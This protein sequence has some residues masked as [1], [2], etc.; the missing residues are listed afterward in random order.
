M[1]QLRALSVAI[2]LGLNMQAMSAT[3]AIQPL[4]SIAVEVNGSIITYGDIERL[5]KELKSRAGNQGVA[6][7]QFVQ[8]AK[9]RLIERALLADAARQQNLKVN[10]AGIDQELEQRAKNDN[11][12]VEKL[13]AKARSL[14][15]TREAYR[16]EVAKDML[17]AYMLNDANAS[18]NISD[19]QINEAMKA[20]NL[21]EAE[22]YTVYTIRRIVLNADN[23]A[24]MP[25]V[26]Q[27]LKQIAQAIEQGSDFGV[28]AKRYSQEAAAVNGGLH[29]VSDFM[30]PENVEKML[31]QL[32]P[33]QFSIPLRS[34]KS[35]Q[36][37][38]LIS[39]RVENDPAKMQRE[40]VRRQLVR[41]AQQQNHEQ[42][43]VQLQNGAVVR[44]Y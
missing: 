11:T 17:I 36:L 15:Y 44:E 38:Q 3:T 19:A 10:Q 23:E 20:G 12:T 39:T 41:Q 29:E 32:Q 31:H 30:L 7:A 40:A 6:D 24:N 21:P 37:V 2:L 43:V 35:W 28:L 4:N 25:A 26:E 22:P 18:I 13:Y 8:A 9:T 34:G 5:V 14:G 33:N 1:N 16:A 42:F 27:R